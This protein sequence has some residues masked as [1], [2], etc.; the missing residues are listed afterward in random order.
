MTISASALRGKNF[1]PRRALF[2]CPAS[3]RQ[4]HLPQEE[5]RQHMGRVKE[6]AE[7]SESPA[8]PALPP[9]VEPDGNQRRQRQ[10]LLDDLDFK[11]GDRDRIVVSAQYMD[12]QNIQADQLTE[13]ALHI[14]LPEEVE[15]QRRQHAR[16]VL[17]RHGPVAQQE[18]QQ[19]QGRGQQHRRNGPEPLKK[20]QSTFWW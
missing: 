13:Q 3:S 19:D 8:V 12:V 17:I 14:F 18:P 4:Q 10:P 15:H 16:A 7:R 20:V 1:F 2:C 6:V 9:P 5:Q 11:A